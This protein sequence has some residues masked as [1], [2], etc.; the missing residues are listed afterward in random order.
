MKYE[1][2]AYVTAFCENKTHWQRE[3]CMR[4]SRMVSEQAQASSLL[5]ESHRPRVEQGIDEDVMTHW[6]KVVLSA[7][8][9]NAKDY[10]QKHTFKG[11]LTWFAVPYSKH[12][13]M[14]L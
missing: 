4:V 14:K 11:G 3:G 6:R 2:L 8:E 7:K 12:A 13:P 5:L 9:G 1:L 10:Q